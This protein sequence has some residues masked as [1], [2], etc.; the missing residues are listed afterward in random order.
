M[1]SNAETAM[2][3]TPAVAAHGVF[4]SLKQAALRRAIEAQ[5]FEYPPRSVPS[6]DRSC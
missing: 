5:V 4:L 1:R 6:S 2:I 3:T